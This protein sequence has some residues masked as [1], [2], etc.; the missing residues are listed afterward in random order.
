MGYSTPRC[1][2][3]SVDQR[4][5]GH[6]GRLPDAY[7]REHTEHDWTIDQLAARHFMPAEAID[8]AITFGPLPPIRLHDLRHTAAS[9]TYRATKDLKVVSELLGHAS[10]HFTGDIYTSIFANADRA[11][12]KAAADIA[13]K[14]S[15]GRNVT[16]MSSPVPAIDLHSGLVAANSQVRRGRAGGAR[17]HDRRIT[18]DHLS[19]SVADPRNP[20][21]LG[22][23]A[24]ERRPATIII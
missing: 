4:C 22:H 5:P 19:A 13:P 18:I 17:T 6:Q 2:C 3:W 21:P 10:V 15:C 11:A 8:T 9:L 23:F 1:R 7:R 20:V 12:A 16:G 24:S 14:N